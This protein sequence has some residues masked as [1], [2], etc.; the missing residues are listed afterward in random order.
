MPT[1]LLGKDAIKG[2]LD[3]R[4]VIKVVE[5]AFRDWAEGNAQ[6]PAKSYIALEKGDFRAMPAAL[7]G[8]V[9]VK[10]V[11]V[12]PQNPSRG[13]PTV[14]ALIIYNDP[15]TGYPLAVMDATDITAYR[16]GAT[17]AISSKYLARPDAQTLGIIGAGR[18]AYTQIL[19]H[20]QLFKFETI[21]VFDLSRVAVEKLVGFFS[22]YPLKESSLPE[23]A[24]CDIVCTLTPARAP[25]VK[26]EWIVPGTHINAIGADAEGKEELEP[27]ILK[28]AVVV[29][30]DLRQASMAGEINVPL[31][32][33]IYNVEEIRGTLGE[34]IIERKKGRE[35]KDAITVF[36]STG[37]AIED[38]AV[39]KLVYE[40]AKRTGQYVS[41]DF[42]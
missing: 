18:Q 20:T 31:R 13:L 28:E 2:L 29:V 41:M 8:A 15:A 12:H 22:E 17:A 16:T 1:I 32:Q 23:A 37:V 7:P 35:S 11:N 38:V 3:I 30:D 36:D 26:K 39:A 40:T 9:G 34:V 4:G 6:M 27:A 25:F 24:A 10:W 19:A 42:V 21:K 14:M 5:Q 33:G